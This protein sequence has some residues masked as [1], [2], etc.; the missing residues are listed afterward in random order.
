[1]TIKLTHNSVP[2]DVA[3]D[4]TAPRAVIVI[5]EAFGVNGH[6]RDVTE[7][8]AAQG[9]YAV[10]PELFHRS[11]SPEVDYDNFPEAMAVMGDLNAGDIESDLRAAADFLGTAGY[12]NQSIGIV[13]Y[14]MGGTVSFY[15]GTLG[16]VGAAA[17]FY[18]GG[19]AAGRF[20]FPTLVELASTL[21]C[22]WIG[23]YGDLDKG[24]PVEQV[25][26]LRT[27]T[28]T[29][30]FDTEVVRYADAEHGFHCDGRP[31]VFNAVDATDAH[32]RTLDFFA[33]HLHDK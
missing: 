14:C 15:A 33:S 28:S 17:S 16:I 4:P 26:A 27:A 10:A 23:I 24:I 19:I 12:A 25:E 22:D 18:G 2:L 13:G 1:M 31:A 3:G 21:R 5:Q 29:S 32:Q 20:G 7:R 8:F 30:N 11:G 9:Y 6:I